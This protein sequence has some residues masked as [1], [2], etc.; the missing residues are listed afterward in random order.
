MALAAPPLAVT[1]AQNQ[2][3]HHKF[4]YFAGGDGGSLGNI[5]IFLR[6]A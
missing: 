6:C 2:I 4:R 3:N 1:R 5:A